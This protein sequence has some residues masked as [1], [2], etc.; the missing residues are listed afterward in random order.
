MSNISQFTTNQNLNLL[1]D[2]LLDELHINR[3]NNSLMSNIRTIFESN[4]KPFTTRSKPSTNIMDLNKQFL[5]QVVLAVN[6]LFPN[7]KQEQNIKRITITD[8]E[9]SEPYKIEDIHA[10]RQS[11][12]EKEVE[13]KRMELE[14]Y[15][16]PQKP[17]DLDFSDKASDGKIKSMDSLVADK[18]AQRNF[19]IEQIQNNNYNNN[20][21]NIDPEKWLSPKETSIKTEKITQEQIMHTN[22][23]TN[24]NTKLKYINIDNDNVSVLKEKK[25]TWND[26]EQ[27]T[28]I[29]QKL[30]KRPDEPISEIIE[31]KQYVEQKSIPLPDVKQEQINRNI[32]QNIQNDPIIPKNEIIKQMNEM[33]SK[34]DNLYELVFKLTNSMKGLILNKN[35]NSEELPNNPDI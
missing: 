30:K 21:I 26:S 19:E 17:R 22:A 34:I 35:D 32:V 27:T 9:I 2:V 33:N 23:N 24:A 4:I 15:M 1:W 28:N 16:T 18:M 3:S 5:S 14:N 6:R 20:T 25:V 11:D 31:E 10:S 12:F 8:E 29:F 7:L 13:R